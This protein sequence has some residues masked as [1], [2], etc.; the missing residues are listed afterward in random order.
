MKTAR[1]TMVLLSNTPS[2]FMA[3]EV[4]LRYLGTVKKWKRFIQHEMIQ[5]H[6]NM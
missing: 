4:F 1:M 5:Q 6:D 3:V 2:D